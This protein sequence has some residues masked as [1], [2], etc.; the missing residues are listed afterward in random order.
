MADHVLDPF[1]VLHVEGVVVETLNLALPFEP[2]AL[3]PVATLVE[4]AG[5]AGGIVGGG[6]E[7]GMLALQL[8]PQHRVSE[9]L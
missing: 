1:L 9:Q 5:E 4:D 3:F 2:F 7:F 6:G 8:H